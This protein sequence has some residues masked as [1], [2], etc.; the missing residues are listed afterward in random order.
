MSERAIDPTPR[1]MWRTWLALGLVW[2]AVLTG[3]V[4]PWGVLFVF[5]IGASL[6]SGVA[7]VFEPVPRATH[8]VLFV[9][10]VLTWFVVALTCFAYDLASVL[11]L[12]AVWSPPS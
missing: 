6:R 1:P 10:I 8:P 3:W 11:P 9:S 5:W 2:L 4:W 12:P 7:H